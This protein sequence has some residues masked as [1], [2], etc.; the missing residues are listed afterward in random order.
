MLTPPFSMAIDR[1]LNVPVYLQIANAMIFQIQQGN[2]RPGAR[3]PG[4]RE[5]AEQLQIQRKTVRAAYDELVAQSWVETRPRKGMFVVS[6]LPD[7]KSHP[8]LVNQPAGSYP[9]QTFFHVPKKQATPARFATSTKPA[10][11]VFNDGFPD[12]RLAPTDL[13]IREY[14]RFANFQFTQKFL[15][16]GPAQGSENLR[17]ELARFLNETRGLQVTASNV[18]ITK[19]SQM[20]MYLIA[21]LLI[22][23]GDAVVVGDP[24]F[25]GAND[26]FEQAGA[27][28]HC[29]LVDARGLDLDAVE[30]VCRRKKV[31]LVYVVPHHHHPTTVTLSPERRMQLLALSEQ[32]GFAILEDDYDYDF[33]YA[34]SPVLPL[35]SADRSGTVIYVGS[36]CKTIAPAI[37]IGF[38]VAPEN[39]IDQATQLRRLIDRQGESLLEEAM[40]NLLKNGDIN[41]HLRKANK[42][43][44]ERRDVF[45]Q[46]L[47]GQ[48][49]NEI[50]FEV[51]DGGMSV[52]ATYTGGVTSKAVAERAEGFGLRVDSGENYSHQKVS[53]PH[54]RLGFA[55]MNAEE[56][57]Q[58]VFLLAKAV[59]S[60]R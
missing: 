49:P 24:G 20:A 46:L 5:L 58:A 39:L 11:R 9:K 2:I 8:I 43:Y 12:T 36:F 22:S 6:N 25:F 53:S 48:L 28:L 59:R 4:S 50:Q 7:I 15:S 10:V 26:V 42:I 18:L 21:Q 19:G 35:A 56:L 44:H 14:R 23:P 27:R 41:R 38:M 40:A 45:C 60:V 52:W 16:Y 33:H 37:R 54:V 3:L 30:A 57:E 32:Y 29:V 1:N 47:H 34:S 17:I 55:S 31:R 13:L 51:P